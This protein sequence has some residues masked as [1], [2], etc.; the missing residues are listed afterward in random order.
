MGAFEDTFEV[1]L[2]LMQADQMVDPHTSETV[3]VEDPDQTVFEHL[4]RCD[5]ERKR[6]GTPV[7]VALMRVKF[8]EGSSAVAKVVSQRRV[9]ERLIRGF[10]TPEFG[11]MVSEGEY[12]LAMFG[13]DAVTAQERVRA[14]VDAIRCEP[15]MAEAKPSIWAG[16]SPVSGDS[17]REALRTA[18]L[19]CELAG[20]QDSGHVELIDL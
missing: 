15:A 4:E 1:K 14:M 12:A 11:R 20:F 7:A 18:R 2:G 19:A 6:R 5:L 17:S 3:E 13:V 9:V 10:P 16:V 8:P